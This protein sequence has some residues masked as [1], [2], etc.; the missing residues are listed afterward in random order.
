MW[1]R[2]S[3]GRVGEGR[4]QQSSYQGVQ[5]RV[6]RHEGGGRE[7]ERSVPGTLQNQLQICHTL[8]TM[9]SRFACVVPGMW[10]LASDFAVF[11]HAVCCV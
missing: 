2:G 6:C 10:F 8:S 1:F 3:A 9:R 4:S 11:W 5:R 7:G